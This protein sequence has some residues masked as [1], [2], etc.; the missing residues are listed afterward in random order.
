MVFN[1]TLFQLYHGVSFIGGGNRRKPPTCRRSLILK[2]PQ[3]MQ[4]SKYIL[5][6]LIHAVF[7]D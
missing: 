6:L 4:K 7:C 2:L 1:A 5:A 3:D